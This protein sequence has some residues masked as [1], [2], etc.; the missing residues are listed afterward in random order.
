MINW[1]TFKT[2][3]HD[4][5]SWEGNKPTETTLSFHQSRTK[6]TI[7]GMKPTETPRRFHQSQTKTTIPGMVIVTLALTAHLCHGEKL[8]AQRCATL[9]SVTKTSYS[10]PQSNQ[11]A[12]HTPPFAM[13]V[14]K[15][16]HCWPHSR[17]HT[18]TKTFEIQ[19]TTQRRPTS[20][21]GLQIQK[22]ESQALCQHPYGT[23]NY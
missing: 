10:E 14:I 2:Q 13:V 11:V 19:P 18:H 5:P 23:S 4:T 21:D 1:P 6:T 9:I 3:S 15:A 8:S 7:A 22:L 16:A 20:S 17:T 12:L